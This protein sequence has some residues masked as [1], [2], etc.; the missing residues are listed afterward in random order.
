M[1]MSSPTQHTHLEASGPDTCTCLRP[2]PERQA[3]CE[4]L[5]Y[6]CLNPDQKDY[7]TAQEW[8]PIWTHS[9][10]GGGGEAY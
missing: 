8:L 6:A 2:T 10:G 3:F 1:P 4:S 9:P 5:D 7:L